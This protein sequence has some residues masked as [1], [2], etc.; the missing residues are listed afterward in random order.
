MIPKIAVLLDDDLLVRM[1]WTRVATHRGI[2]LHVFSDQKLFFSN[3]SRFPLDTPI[4]L[5][6]CLEEDCRGEDLAQPLLNLGF[7]CL[8]LTSGYPAG[9]FAHCENLFQGIIGKECPWA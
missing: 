9:H 3:L 5:D 7:S 4:Y 8:Y 6:S 2:E 1:S